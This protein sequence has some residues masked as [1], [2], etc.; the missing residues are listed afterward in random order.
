MNKRHYVTT[1]AAALFA[2]GTTTAMAAA[3]GHGGG[4]MG[5]AGGGMGGAG[6]VGGNSAGHMSASA[7]AHSNGFNSGDRDAGLARA[8]DRSDT[9]ADRAGIQPGKGHRHGRSH[10]MT[11][12]KREAFGH[13]ESKP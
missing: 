9:I 7:Q 8:A 1:L 6:G 4:G 13:L 11:A 5:G 2:L 12:S 3:G 10:T